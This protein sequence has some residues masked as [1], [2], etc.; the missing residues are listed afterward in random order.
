ML[1]YVL[2][3]VNNQMRFTI[4]HIHAHSK[5]KQTFTGSRRHSQRTRWLGITCQGQA[6][7]ESG[8]F[9]SWS[10]SNSGSGSGVPTITMGRPC[11]DPFSSSRDSRQNRALYLPP[12]GSRCFQR[13][14]TLNGIHQTRNKR[15]LSWRQTRA[16]YPQLPDLPCFLDQ[17]HHLSR[18]SLNQPHCR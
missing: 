1:L 12:H 13:L 11:F 4:N 7:R 5:S 10:R 18:C 3:R 17:S 15:N 16:M 2:S 8:T 14:L 6:Q 9:A